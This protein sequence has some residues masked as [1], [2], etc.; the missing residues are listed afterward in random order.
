ME[1]ARYGVRSNAV[2]PSAR[3]RI[4]TSLQP[5]QA[6]EFDVF[7]PDTYLRS[8]SGSP[9]ADC[10]ATNQVFQA[11]GDRVE[12]IAP[13]TIAVD[14]RNGGKA[15]TVAELDA[16]LRTALPPAVELRISWKD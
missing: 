15:W 4:E 1:G 16:A 12:V 3:T 7:N 6:G 9:R 2:S 11:Y 5:P 8:S 13:S 14:V 10:P